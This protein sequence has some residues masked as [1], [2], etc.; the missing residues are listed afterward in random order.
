MYRE[1]ILEADSRTTAAHTKSAMRLPMPLRCKRSHLAQTRSKK[2]KII[3]RSEGKG[4]KTLK[5]IEKGVKQKMR[6]RVGK[7]M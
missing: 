7:L 1:V 5:I 6:H 3:V 4:W 2:L